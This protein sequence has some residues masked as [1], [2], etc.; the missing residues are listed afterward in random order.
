MRPS[1]SFAVKSRPTSAGVRRIVSAKRSMFTTSMPIPRITIS[2][3]CGSRSLPCPV[4]VGCG[5]RH[6]ILTPGPHHGGTPTE[7][8]PPLAPGQGRAGA[9]S[10][11]SLREGYSTVTDFARLRGWSTS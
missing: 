4:C 7:T 1:L 3:S 9:P 11:F 8:A 10:S 2:P 6:P 5:L